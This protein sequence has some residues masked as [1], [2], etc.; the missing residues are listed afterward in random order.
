MY[1]L[2]DTAFN[3]LNV[4]E[5]YERVVAGVGDDHDIR[6]L[7]CLMLSKLIVLT[8]DETLSR[9]NDLAEHFRNVV[10][11]KPKDN[12][13]KQELEKHTEAQK[14]VLKVSIQVNK[15]VIEPAAASDSRINTWTS[16]WEW[17]SKEFSPLVKT[18]EEEMKE[19]ER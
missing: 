12:A 6:I 5:F 16:Y 10:G 11:F 19:K 17:A 15:S 13:V 4:P 3:R 8:P 14:S 18:V 9:L 1:A 2:L 7:C